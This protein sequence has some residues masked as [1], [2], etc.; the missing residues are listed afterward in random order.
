M[1]N[2]ASFQQDNIETNQIQPKIWTIDWSILIDD[3]LIPCQ[4]NYNKKFEADRRIPHHRNGRMAGENV[5][6]LQ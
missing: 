5:G 2:K 3:G 6:I 1:S 4:G